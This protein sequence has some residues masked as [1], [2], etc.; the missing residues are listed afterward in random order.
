MKSVLGIL[1]WQTAFK[2]KFALQSNA[3]EIGRGGGGGRES[4]DRLES[5]NQKAEGLI[6]NSFISVLSK[7]KTYKGNVLSCSSRFPDL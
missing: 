6:T 2:N 7:T 5:S 3:L 4:S 1:T